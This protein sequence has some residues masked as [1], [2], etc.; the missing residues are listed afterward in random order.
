MKLRQTARQETRVDDSDTLFGARI[1]K[2]STEFSD[3]RRA[4]AAT[5]LGAQSVTGKVRRHRPR[6][7]PSKRESLRSTL[8]HLDGRPSRCMNYASQTQFSTSNR[9]DLLNL[10]EKS[11]Q[12]LQPGVCGKTIVTRHSEN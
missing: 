11:H 10:D 3:S 12:V 6:K 1:Q 9:Y 8:C 5:Y 2:S 7:I 4:T